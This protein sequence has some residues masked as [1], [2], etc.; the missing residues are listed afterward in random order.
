[1]GKYLKL[2]RKAAVT[3]K[4][5]KTAKVVP[6]KTSRSKNRAQG[7]DLSSPAMEIPKESRPRASHKAATKATEAT[8]APAGV[9]ARAGSAR[10]ISDERSSSFVPLTV[11]EALAE[12]GSWGTGAGRNAE[13]YRRGELSEEKAVEYVTCAILARRGTSFAGW[14]RHAHAVRKALSL[15][16]H[17]LDPKA[18]KACNG[19]ARNLI[20]NQGDATREKAEV[21]QWT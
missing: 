1:V 8:K 19:Y 16:A 2:A 10:D 15:C 11:S 5:A 3:A 14:R 21:G 6:I 4:E 7:H 13:L 20:E 12:M 17:E 9:G 18:C